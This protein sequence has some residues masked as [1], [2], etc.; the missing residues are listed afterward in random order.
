MRWLILLMVLLSSTIKAG[1]EEVECKLTWTIGGKISS[2]VF[3]FDVSDI[4]F[5]MSSRQ[6]YIQQWYMGYK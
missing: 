3:E 4:A 2:P 1:D 6:E 5:K